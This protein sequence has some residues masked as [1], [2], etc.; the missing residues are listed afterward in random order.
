MTINELIE[1]AHAQA[2][3]KGFWDQE[4]NIGELLMLIVS[5][6]GEA[7]EA[8]R[9]GVKTKPDLELF[10]RMVNPCVPEDGHW[11]TTFEEMVKDSFADELADIVIRIADLM[12]GLGME[13]D[14]AFDGATIKEDEYNVGSCLLGVTSS[15][16]AMHDGGKW[17]ADRMELTV[18]IG[19]VEAIAKHENIDLW[20]HI[21]LKLAYNET[22]PRLHGKAY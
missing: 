16:T 1:R 8:H 2:N 7:L 9:S 10:D 6:C 19:L 22:R 11:Q 21:E 5:E 12:G 18:A 14:N 20:R 3:A 17:V 15:M 4:R 13:P